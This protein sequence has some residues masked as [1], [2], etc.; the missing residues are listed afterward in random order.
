MWG[1]FVDPDTDDVHAAP[2][3]AD[4]ALAGTLDHVI[5]RDCP[6]LPTV[7]RDGPLDDPVWSHHDRTWPG[8]NE[9]RVQ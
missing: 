1:A 4:G 3:D 6:C 8:A 5:A 7:V 2:V 9:E